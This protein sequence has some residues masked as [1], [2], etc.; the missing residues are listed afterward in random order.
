M[1]RMGA[2]LTTEQDV[3][4]M[5]ETLRSSLYPNYRM[6]IR[7]GIGGTEET[8][9]LA[10]VSS[11]I[12]NALDVM[13]VYRDVGAAHA[14]SGLTVNVPALA[15]VSGAAMAAR[16][17]GF[18]PDI[19]DNNREMV[20][21]FLKKFIGAYYPEFVDRV[22]FENPGPKE[23]FDNPLYR[24]LLAAASAQALRP[25]TALPKPEG[26]FPRFMEDR[27]GEMVAERGTAIEGRRKEQTLGSFRLFPK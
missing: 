5:F 2:G 24:Q 10:R 1:D 9:I 11:Y 20:F 23:I 8:D 12:V 7:I 22:S 13:A 15:V 25:G 16:I 18:N 27:S 6:N 4:L 14:G 17:N 26:L 19:A 21:G 3:A